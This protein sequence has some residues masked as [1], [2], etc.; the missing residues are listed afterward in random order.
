MTADGRF[1]VQDLF[2]QPL[3][4]DNGGLAGNADVVNEATSSEE[5]DGSSRP[6]YGA[7]WWG[8]GATVRAQKRAQLVPAHDGWGLCSPGRWPPA[9]RLL[10]QSVEDQ[11]LT[12]L[13]IEFLFDAEATMGISLRQLW[14][15]L[16]TNKFTECPFPSDC[17]VRGRM[18]ITSLLA[19]RITRAPA[20]L[21][22]QLDVRL[23]QGH[24]RVWRRTLTPSGFFR[25][26]PPRVTY[27]GSILNSSGPQRSLNVS[28]AGSSNPQARVTLQRWSLLTIRRLVTDLACCRHHSKQMWPRGG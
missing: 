17:I 27:S 6:K 11:R 1:E 14:C 4:R 5:E 16:A 18:A 26:S 10:P 12:R 9:R 24:L 28:G 3:P 15:S 21:E 23:L 7:G 22:Q 8:R 25:S 19:E 20:D 2:A 13:M